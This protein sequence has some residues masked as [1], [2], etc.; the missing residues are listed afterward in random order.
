MLKASVKKKMSASSLS[1]L[2][3]TYQVQNHPVPQ[4]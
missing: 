1:A 3:Q 4:K 2:G